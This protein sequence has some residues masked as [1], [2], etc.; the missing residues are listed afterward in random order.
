MTS[1]TTCPGTTGTDSPGTTT[2]Q[3]SLSPRRG[4]DLSQ[5]CPP[6]PKGAINATN[7]Y[8]GLATLAEFWPTHRHDDQSTEATAAEVTSGT[9]GAGQSLANLS[10]GNHF[11]GFRTRN[12]VRLAKYSELT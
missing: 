3:A 9:P 5:S 11:G 6:E 7:R 10:R 8:E 1:G 12:R 4:E 2:G